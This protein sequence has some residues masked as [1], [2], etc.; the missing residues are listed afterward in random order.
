MPCSS[1]SSTRPFRTL[2]QR[3]PSGDARLTQP[4]T[5]FILRPR[6]RPEQHQRPQMSFP[7]DCSPRLRLAA[8]PAFEVT[9]AATCAPCRP[10]PA[11]TKRKTSRPADRS[12][13]RSPASQLPLAPADQDSDL[14]GHDPSPL[15]LMSLGCSGDCGGPEGRH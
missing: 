4:C 15:N 10:G 9:F 12:K 13:T 7:P 8:D 3:A 14:L 2:I 6:R 5:S 1:S 11:A